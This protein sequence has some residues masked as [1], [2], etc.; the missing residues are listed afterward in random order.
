MDKYFNNLLVLQLI[1]RSTFLIK[2][3]NNTF[4]KQNTIDSINKRV[5]NKNFNHNVL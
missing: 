3:T 1:F 5:V 2:T 4:K